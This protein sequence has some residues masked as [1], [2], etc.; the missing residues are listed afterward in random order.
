MKIVN[1]VLAIGTAFILGALITLGIKAFY[2]EPVAPQYPN[3]PNAYPA[4]PCAKNDTACEQQ[5]AAYTAQQDQYNAAT[6]AYTAEM[7]VYNRNVFIVANVIGVIVFI[8]GFFIILYGAL[9][10]Q[11]TP[12][13]I[14]LAGLWGIL[15]GYGRG[16]GSIDD[17][18]KFIIGLVVALIVVGGSMWLMQKHR[19]AV[20]R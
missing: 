12:I 19:K 16:W 14:M 7:N 17:R 5:V 9:A 20:M 13:G 1:V 6:D 11:G 8:V 3:Y 15:Y 10:D 2:P 18:F 4:A